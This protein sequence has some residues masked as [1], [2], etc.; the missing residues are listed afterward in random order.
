MWEGGIAA[1]KKSACVN[2]YAAGVDLGLRDRPEYARYCVECG[3]CSSSTRERPGVAGSVAQAGIAG[4]GIAR[5]EELPRGEPKGE[6]WRPL[7]TS[8]LSF[9]QEWA[10]K[11]PEDVGR[12]DLFADY[13]THHDDGLSRSCRPAHL[14]AS[15]VIVD[16][17]ENAVL[18]VLHRKV[19]RWLQPGGHCELG[20]A[21]LAGAALREAREE[22]GISE[23]H[24]ASDKPLDLDVHAAPCTSDPATNHYD[25]RFLALTH[26]AP[27]PGPQREVIASQWFPLDEPPSGLDP[28][29]IRLLDRARHW[30]SA[31]R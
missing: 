11:D 15:V 2:S 13:L 20:D 30:L 4:S 27:N 17:A 22:T 29:T 23:L 16:P 14:T 19:G 26:R 1:F 21:T 3:T 5:T 24:L 12:R 9:L 31:Y 7:R 18:L 10:P 6:R 8:A 28:G 25:V